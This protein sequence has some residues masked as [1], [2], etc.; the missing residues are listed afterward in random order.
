MNFVLYVSHLSGLRNETA[1]GVRCYVVSPSLSYIFHLLFTHFIYNRKFSRVI[2]C[3]QEEIKVKKL[4]V[5]FFKYL[6]YSETSFFIFYK[7]YNY[8]YYFIN[9]KRNPAY[10]NKLLLIRWFIDFWYNSCN[11]GTPCIILVKGK[12][13]FLKTLIAIG[14]KKKT[15]LHKTI[16]N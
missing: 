2:Y 10:S 16:L 11:L 4:E 14:K 6:I 5:P 13:P 7:N 8:Y 15:G 12:T 3:G 1:T 9:N